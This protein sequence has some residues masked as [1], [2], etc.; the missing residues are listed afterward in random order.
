MKKKLKSSFGDILIS[1][2]HPLA[3][4]ANSFRMTPFLQDQVC[5]IGQKEVFE[6]G[7][8]TIFRLMGI[9]VSNKQ[10][11]RISEYYG[12]R[13]ESEAI[14]GKEQL[15]AS[16]Y[17]EKKPSEFRYGMVDGSMVFTKEEKWKEIKLGRVFKGSDNIPISKDRHWI[18][19]SAYCAYLGN[20]QPFLERFELLL[21]GF[22]NIVF[23]ADGAKWF[24]DWVT[25][26]YPQATQILDFYHVKEYLCGFAKLVF[27]DKQQRIE[28]INLQ[29]K[30]FF[31]DKVDEVIT[32][33]KAFTGLAGDTSDFQ[34]KI[35]T[36][37]ENNQTRMQYGTYKKNGFMIGSGP[38]ESAHRNIIQ[39]RLKLS[40]QRWSKQG[41]QQIANL[42][43]AHKSSN[44][45]QVID[46]IKV[47]KIVA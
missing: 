44:W 47:A 33:I 29:Q 25:T 43:I 24:W 21:I 41:V 31:R 16:N 5:F 12:Q 20:F 30:L 39:K 11:Q 19:E 4:M 1:N 23:I 3:Q 26:F 46:M 45:H 35:L 28:W 32:G 42:R 27:Q 36:Y 15:P 2:K 22:P 37:Y 14:E 6:E 34:E 18:Q 13:L 40:G 8:E 10:I 38:I 17:A 9:D 7:S